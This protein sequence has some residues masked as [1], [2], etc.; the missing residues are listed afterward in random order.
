[1]HSPESS[2]PRFEDLPWRAN[3][4][5]EMLP[6]AS[7]TDRSPF[8]G[9]GAD[10]TAEL[11]KSSL[12]EHPYDFAIESFLAED[13]NLPEESP[14]SFS[15]TGISGHPGKKSG[16]SMISEYVKQLAELNGTLLHNRANR[17]GTWHGDQSQSPPFA[18]HSDSSVSLSIGQTLR[19]CQHLLGILQ[20]IQ[21][22]L[23]SQASGDSW[24]TRASEDEPAFPLPGITTERAQQTDLPASSLDLS[25]LFSILA[26]YAYIVE[27]LELLFTTILESLTQ[28]T[29]RVPATLVGTSLDG[30][31]L[32]GNNTLQLEFLLYVSSN[33]L[34]KIESLLIGTP[35][36]MAGGSRSD[37]LLSGKMA[38]YLESLYDHNDHNT[39]EASSGGEIRP[40]VL[41]RQI[42]AALKK[43]ET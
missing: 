19:H 34:G 7:I 26:C 27:D 16:A 21:R 13:T 24:Q 41:I 36:G 37:G 10:A 18:S 30:F 22:N 42:Q 1:M 25:S 35:K 39:Q 14:I 20:N 28:A 2:R 3:G 31:K 40:K 15:V 8:D 38:G 33:L 12:A 32:D 4:D 43:L 17:H 5:L 6:T 29:P 9:V 23:T 11:G